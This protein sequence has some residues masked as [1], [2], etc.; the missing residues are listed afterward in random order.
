MTV[1]AYTKADAAAEAAS[2]AAPE[3][4][5][6][7][8]AHASTTNGASSSAETAANIPEASGG[9]CRYSGTMSRFIAS[10]SVLPSRAQTASTK[11]SARAIFMRCPAALT[12]APSA[13]SSTISCRTPSCVPT[14]SYVS[15]L[16]MKKLPKKYPVFFDGSLTR[17]AEKRVC[18]NTDTT[19]SV[20]RVQNSGALIRG[21]PVSA[22]SPSC[23]S[24]E[25]A[26]EI[27]PGA[28]TVSESV[29]SSSSPLERAYPCEHAQFLP[30]HPSGFG[31]AVTCTTRSDSAACPAMIAPVSSSDESSTHTIS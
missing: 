11:C 25:A 24:C 10:H 29:N 27:A 5:G 7:Q 18:K 31:A 22:S 19:G 30:I 1:P 15:F 4:P 2:S 28:C 16:M 26:A 13:P 23:K 6:A 8:T 12:L 21:M 14:D 20:T 9:L 3:S 17:S